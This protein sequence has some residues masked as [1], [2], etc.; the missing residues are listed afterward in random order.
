MQQNEEE[1][2]LDGYSL[3]ASALH[4]I[5]DRKCKVRLAEEAWMTVEEGRQVIENIIKSGRVTYGINTGFGAFAATIIP[6]ENICRLQ[7]NLIRSHA[8]GVGGE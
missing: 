5:G 1:I 4:A 8:A 3:T 2:A 7:E 6:Q